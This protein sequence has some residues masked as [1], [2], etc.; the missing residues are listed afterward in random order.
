MYVN[1]GH[2]FIDAMVARSV[3]I[4]RNRGMSGDGGGWRLRT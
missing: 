4:F 2:V 1:S 3:N